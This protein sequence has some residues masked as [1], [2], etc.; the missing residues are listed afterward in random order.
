[1]TLAEQVKAARRVST[2][3]VAINTPDPAAT[4]QELSAAINGSAP[5]LEWD[6]VRSFQ[7]INAEGREAIGYVDV[8]NA[9][10][11][12]S[13]AFVEAA[14]LPGG[15]VLFIHN[16]QSFLGDAPAK[17]A[18]WNL[19]DLFKADKRMIVLLGQGIVLPPELAGDVLTFD[20]PLPDGELIGRIIDDV[21]QFAGVTVP[22]ESR[23]KAVEALTGL[24]AFQVE[25]VAA[26]SLTSDGIDVDSLWERKRR[27]IEQTPGLTVYRGK[28]S[29]A[30]IGGVNAVKDYAKRLVNGRSKPQAVVWLDEIEKAMAGSKGDTSGVSQDFLGTLLSHME[31]H[32]CYGM[33]FVGPPGCAKSAVAKATGN[34]AGIPTVRLDL[35]GMK[36]SLVGQ[37]EQQLRAALKVITA[38]SNG[39]SLWIATS[40]SVANMDTA[41][42]RRFPDV[43]YFDLPDEEER[44]KIWDIWLAKYEHPEWYPIDDTG[45]VGANI[46]KACEK[47]WMLD[48]SIE[49]AARYI[50]PVGKTAASEIATLR[51]QADGKFLSASQPGV[52]TKELAK[53]A[54]RRA[55]TDLQ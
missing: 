5:K 9:R 37:S 12:P 54:R 35:G 24:P 29:F 6:I 1:M 19:R 46:R 31:D 41:M 2:P 22:P 51:A 8:D 26:M 48:C 7:P 47:A 43:F 18:L 39:R 52:Y 17:Q 10:Y 53:P 50:V 25:Q 42:M 15:T 40:N 13:A 55:V 38:V 45:W 44:A 11:N 21:S 16:A 20:E 36:G 27:Q 28:D 23:S 30:D 33:M 34:E 32:N 4:I 14:K 49:E 3:I